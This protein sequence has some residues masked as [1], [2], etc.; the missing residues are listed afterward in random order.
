MIWKLK[1]LNPF[2]QRNAATLVVL[3]LLLPRETISQERNFT[4]P[5]FTETA[6]ITT[7][8]QIYLPGDNIPFTAIVLES[9]SW[10]P[11]SLSRVLRVE[12]LDTAGNRISEGE[13]L[14]DNSTE[15]GTSMLTLP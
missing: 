13:Y 9:D 15:L 5:L 10:I 3:F 8:R 7:D 2:N 14:L 12:L 6:W 11:S 4:G 1:I